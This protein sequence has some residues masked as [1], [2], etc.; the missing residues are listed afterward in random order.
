MKRKAPGRFTTLDEQ[1]CKLRH[2]NVIVP[3]EERAKL[4]L[5]RDGYYS[6]I[7]GYK[8]VFI[9]K[10]ETNQRGDDWY[11]DGTS[12]EHFLLLYTFDKALRRITM[13]ALLNAEGLMKSAAVYAFC[14]Y[15]R[16]IEAYLD[17]ANYCASSD[18]QNRKQYTKNLIKLLS[19]MQR[20]HDNVSKDYVRHYL[21][22]YTS[23]PLWVVSNVL[24]FGNLSNFYDLQKTEVKSAIC[25]NIRKAAELDVDGFGISSA[26]KAFSVLSMYRNICA[27]EE[28]LYCARVGKHK[29]YSFGD[30]LECLSQVI[31]HEDM[32]TYASAVLKYIK[33][34]NDD[35]IVSVVYGGLGIAEKDLESCICESSSS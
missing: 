10:G 4:Y 35:E 9:D 27:H 16:D 23:V 11:K 19:T 14:Y 22:N 26:R 13:D 17:P 29:V 12:F 24:T 6:M 18:Y 32:S 28:R 7:N 25:Q 3:D 2:R 20:A 21:D 33:L 8:D 5:L 30:M 34:I 1:I 15:N 31:C